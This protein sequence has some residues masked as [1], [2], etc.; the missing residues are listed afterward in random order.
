MPN[1]RTPRTDAFFA[2]FRAARGIADTD[3]DVARFG[4][5]EELSDKLLG[6]VLEGRKRATCCLVQQ[7]E[8][9]KEGMARIGGYC[10][11]LDGRDR[12]AAIWRTTDVAVKPVNQVDDAFAWDEGEGDRTRADWL[13]AHNEYHRA[14]AAREGFDYDDGMP[15]V[16]E[17][18]TIVWPPEHADP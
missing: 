14:L 10:V 15:A 16:F 3:Y 5:T 2:A 13:R 1:T 4:W 12:P 17:R 9:G 11:V 8:T 18:F 6:L 7:I